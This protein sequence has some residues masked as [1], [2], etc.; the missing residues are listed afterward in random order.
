[1]SETRQ[2]TIEQFYKF[3]GERKLMG[4]KCSK[5]GKIL[6]P[7]RP[8]CPEC[9][10]DSLSWIELEN[11]GKLLTYTIIYVAPEKFQSAAPYAFG[12]IELG[13]DVRLPGMIQ[14]VKHEDIRVGM[15]LKVDFDTNIPSTWPKWPRYFFRPP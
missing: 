15:E 10:S 14:G 4:A 3:I 12:I 6:V 2:F 5:C 11:R 8:I 9:L 7:P 13:N 1:M